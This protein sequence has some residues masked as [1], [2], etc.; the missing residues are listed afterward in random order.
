VSDVG[1]VLRGTSAPSVEALSPDAKTVNSYEAGV[2]VGHSILSASLAGFLSTSE[3]GSTY[4]DLPELSLIRSPE[5][6][7][8]GEATADVQVAEPLAVGGTITWMEGKRDA[9]EDGSF[10]TYLPGNRIP[11]TK[12][13]GYVKV[14]PIEGVQGRL[15][16]LRSGSRDRFE[17]GERAYGEGPINSYTLVDLSAQVDVGPGTV[18][19]GVQNLFDTYYF[20]VRSQFTNFGG[21]YTPGR[22]RNLNLSYTVQW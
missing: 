4:G 22:G 16:V 9:D 20:P 13:T 6:V 5:R 8:G 2:R 10:D 19:L 12:I 17:E 11:P 14:T 21:G 15:Q 3:L 7:Y 1:R 18:A